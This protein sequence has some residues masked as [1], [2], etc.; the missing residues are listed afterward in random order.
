V[1]EKSEDDGGWGI[2]RKG[3]ENGAFESWRE[4]D[5]SA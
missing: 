4:G 1:I 5:G 2:E 3:E